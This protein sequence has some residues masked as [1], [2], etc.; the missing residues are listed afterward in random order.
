MIKNLILNSFGIVGKKIFLKKF[1]K[2]KNNNNF[3]VNPISSV[4]AGHAG[5]QAAFHLVLGS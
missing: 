2:K 5:L 3:P 1:F 4:R